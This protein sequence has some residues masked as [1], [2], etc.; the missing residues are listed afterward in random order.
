MSIG[1]LTRWPPDFIGID[2][3]CF[4]FLSRKERKMADIQPTQG[5]SSDRQLFVSSV[6]IYKST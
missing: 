2:F 4:F 6:G 3:F 5:N 1:V